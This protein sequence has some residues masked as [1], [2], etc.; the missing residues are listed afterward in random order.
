[1]NNDEKL[2]YLTGECGLTPEDTA[3]IILNVDTIDD[4]QTN[5]SISQYKSILTK[6]LEAI[7]TRELKIIE[8]LIEIEIIKGEVC[9]SDLFIKKDHAYSNVH[10]L[11]KDIVTWLRTNNLSI[12]NFLNDSDDINNIT[13]PPS[14]PLLNI[15]NTTPP[16]S[17]PLLNINNTT[18]PPSKPLQDREKDR[19]LTVIGLLAIALADKNVGGGYGTKDKPN[20]S[21][22]AELLSTYI[23]KEQ[24]TGISVRT[25]RDRIGIGL[26][27]LMDEGSKLL[28]QLK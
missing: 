14:K 25:N 11:K 17:K 2:K 21:K 24:D 7:A 13:P 16:P 9:I 27:L 1:M 18:P 28:D 22:I 15:N 23:P 5:E 26:K 8:D 12:P 3:L 6:I 20:N 10:I 4:L 19:L